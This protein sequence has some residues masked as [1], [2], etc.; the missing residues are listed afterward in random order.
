M[1]SPDLQRIAHI[2]DYCIE[3][4]ATIDR[5]GNSFEIFEKDTDYQKSVS[6]SILQIGELCGKLSEDFR[7]ET[8]GMI[9]WAAIRGMRNFF[10]HNYGSMSRSEIWKT[11]IKDIPPLLEFCE[12]TLRNNSN[13]E[14][15]WS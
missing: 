3:I 11:A 6:F 9:P 10:A 4:G 2:R 5:Y 8:A 12:Q 13:G 14:Q 7:K 1:L 15:L